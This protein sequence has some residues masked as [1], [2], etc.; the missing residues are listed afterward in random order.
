VISANAPAD[1]RIHETAIAIARRCLWIIR[2]C[3]REEEW[4]DAMLEFYTVA[5]TEIEELERPIHELERAES[6]RP[7][8]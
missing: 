6:S 5:R 3:L 8:D 7:N 2:V 1:P 4:P